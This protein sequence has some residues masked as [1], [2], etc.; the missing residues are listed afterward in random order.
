M[1][2]TI[3]HR[4]ALSL[5]TNLEPRAARL[6]SA[7]TRLAE[8]PGTRIVAVSGEYETEPVDVPPEFAALKFLNQAVLVETEMPV[9]DF[10]AAMHAIEDELGRVRTVRNGPRT[11]DLDLIFFD[12]LFRDDPAITLPHPR[13]WRRDFVIAPLREIGVDVVAEAKRCIRGGM[14]ARRRAVAEPTRKAASAKICADLAR[15]FATD[16]ANGRPPT[17]AAYLATPDEIDLTE[18]LNSFIDRGGI[19]AVPTW[20]GA[21]YELRRLASLAKDALRRGPMKVYEPINTELIAAEKIDCWLVPGLAFTIGGL[22]LGYGGG[23]YDRLLAAARTDAAKFGIA[24]EFQILADL[25]EAATDIRLG[26]IFSSDI[27]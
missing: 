25:P 24:Y 16:F 21:A 26:A 13:A 20:N 7:R 11:I 4:A 27:H 1:N 19:A 15:R 6:R 9:E 23:W 17:I 8:L 12:G 2:E 14:R 5:G 22:R 3:H 10:S 18:F